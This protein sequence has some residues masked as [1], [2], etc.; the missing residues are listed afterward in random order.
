MWLISPRVAAVRIEVPDKDGKSLGMHFVHG[1]AIQQDAGD[2]L[3]DEYYGHLDEGLDAR[4]PGDFVIFT[5]DANCSIGVRADNEHDSVRGEHGEPHRSAA[6]DFLYVGRPEVPFRCN[7]PFPRTK[8]S[9][10][11]RN[12]APPPNE[13]SMP[14]RPC[15]RPKRTKA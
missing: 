11:T 9:Q 4:Q 6:G 2:I 10:R 5:T 13:E 7:H 8:A 12:V 3:R 15:V 14:E 1:R